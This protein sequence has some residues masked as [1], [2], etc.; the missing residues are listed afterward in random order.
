MKSEEWKS[1]EE[2]S[3]LSERMTFER[4]VSVSL[5]VSESRS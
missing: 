1:G 4:S 3:V 5:S 2:I